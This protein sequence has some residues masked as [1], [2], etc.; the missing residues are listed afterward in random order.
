MVYVYLADGFEEMEAIATIDF[1]RRA[2]IEVATVAVGNRAVVGAHDILVEADLLTEHVKLTDELTAI[3]LPGGLSGVKQIA[4][5]E[6]VKKAL[7][8]AAENNVLIAAICAAPTVLGQLGLLEGKQ[9]VCYPGHEDK[10]TGAI[11]AS[12]PVVVSDTVITARAAGVTLEFAKTVAAA[13]TDQQ[14]ADKVYAAM[15]GQSC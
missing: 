7:L 9:A 11:L 6:D 3:V 8:F 5:S 12:E 15:Y 14:T 1:L 4:A 13:L 10:L 2:G